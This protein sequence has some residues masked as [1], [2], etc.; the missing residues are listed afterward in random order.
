[1]R[2]WP[3]VVA[4]VLLMAMV[5]GLGRLVL[6]L[7]AVQKERLRS[8]PVG[9]R[10]LLEL[11]DVLRAEAQRVGLAITEYQATVWCVIRGRSE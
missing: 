3:A 4:G 7:V 1:M 8:E 9:D 10:R 5:L 11:V 6:G 2:R